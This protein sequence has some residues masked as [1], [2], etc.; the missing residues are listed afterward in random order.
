LRRRGTLRTDPVDPPSMCKGSAGAARVAPPPR[1][2]GNR[3][4][5]LVRRRDAA[6]RACGE[7]QG[8]CSRLVGDPLCRWRAT[9]APRRRCGFSRS[10]A[11]VSRR[12]RT[13]CWA[14]ASLGRK[15]CAC[16]RVGR[17]ADRL[18]R[19]TAVRRRVR[20]WSL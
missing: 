5:R 3:R 1:G 10:H 15:D 16:H 20:D 2:K 9:L 7:Q 6:G 14:S 12:R 4:G 18:V 8:R 13:W 19:S 11:S 17:V